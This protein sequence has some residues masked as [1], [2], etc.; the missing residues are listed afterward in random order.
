[1]K[2][3]LLQFR[4]II[5]KVEDAAAREERRQGEVRGALRRSARGQSL[6]NRLNTQNF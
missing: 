4:Q 5:Q 3:I 2:L 6:M 1:M